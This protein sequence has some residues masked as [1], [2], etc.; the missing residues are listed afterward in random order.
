[1]FYDSSELQQYSNDPWRSG[2]LLAC[3]KAASSQ[4]HNYTAMAPC[5]SIAG[6][7]YRAA[8][9]RPHAFIRPDTCTGLPMLQAL[10]DCRAASRTLWQSSRSLREA[11]DAPVGAAECDAGPH[12]PSEDSPL[13]ARGKA[14]CATR[15]ATQCHIEAASIG[16]RAGGTNLQAMEHLRAAFSTRACVLLS[17]RVYD[18]CPRCQN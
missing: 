16:T 5:H 2:G 3:Q 7:I 4:L 9:S 15:S 14:L 10:G 13:L 1:M 18:R 8:T 6:Y 11:D 12:N 17:T